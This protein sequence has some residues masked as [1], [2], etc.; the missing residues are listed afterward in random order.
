M[1]QQR[2]RLWLGAIACIAVLALGGC[3]GPSTSGASGS[4]TTSGTPGP[5]STGTPGTT[6][7]GTPGAAPTSTP[8]TQM[9]WGS[10]LYASTTGRGNALTITNINPASGKNST[11]TTIPNS[12]QGA[13]DAI[14][15]NGQ[16]VAYHTLSGTTASYSAA[17]IA[18]LGAPQSLGQVPGAQGTAVWEHDN[19]HLAVTSDGVITILSMGG[20]PQTITNIYAS[21][22]VGFSNDDTALFYVAAG[23]AITQGPG[24]LYRLPLNDTTHPVELTPR[25]GATH[26]L[27]SQDG[28]TV[29][30]NNTGGSGTQA[31]YSTSAQNGGTQT[32][33][34]QNAGVPVGFTPSGALLYVLLQPSGPALMQ[35][36]ASGNDTTVVA[37]LVAQGDIP[38]LGLDVAVAPDGSGVAALAALQGSGYGISYTDLTQ[39]TPTPKLLVPLA[40]ASLADLLGFDT[41]LLAA[42]S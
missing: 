4:S 5:T 3:K 20:A 17:N 1:R 10:L 22:I 32:I 24:A 42:G 18:G 23:D 25:E 6:A 40:A 31:I 30:Y 19:A 33:V 7:T 21:Q 2:M 39:S 28:Q 8:G 9:S 36:A 14:S 16:L 29:Y 38:N 37:H 12:S 41:A 11:V 34:R 13:V 27:L 35:V 15:P 26:F